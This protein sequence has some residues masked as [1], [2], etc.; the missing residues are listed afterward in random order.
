MRLLSFCLVAASTYTPLFAQTG[1]LDEHSKFGNS[2]L[3]LGQPGEHWQIEVE[4]GVPGL[5]EGVSLKG[6][7]NVPQT[8]DVYF[9]L[10]GGW[11][12]NPALWTG[13][14]HFA[15]GPIHN[16][17]FLDLSSVGIQLQAGDLF[18]IEIG[19]SGLSGIGMTGDTTAANRPPPYHRDLY[20]NGSSICPSQCQTRIG[21]ETW[22]LTGVVLQL[23]GTCP[24]PHTLSVTGATPNGLV[25]IAW[26]HQQGQA[27][28]GVGPCAGG[29]T[30]LDRPRLLLFLVA[31][32]NGDVVQN[33]SV[34]P[35]ACGN[36]V[37]QAMDLTTCL[38]TN[39]VAP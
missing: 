12:T 25:G 15:G 19:G 38:P 29:Q 21:F 35:A 26:S 39:M 36:V 9:R 11:N 13:Q 31:D 33:I 20:F 5:L 3:G 7:S 24:G 6:R 14:I 30:M 18:V 4:A 1:A 10:G 34:P 16:R 22:I 17:F 23:T 37:V 2:N 32:A 28:I 27:S 8:V